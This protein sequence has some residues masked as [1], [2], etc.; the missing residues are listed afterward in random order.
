MA[1]AD[2]VIDVLKAELKAR[3][4][5]YAE[6]ARRIGMSEASVK[7]MFAERS[8]TL[9][10]L[11][12][13]CGAA[14]LEFSELTRGFSREQHL[15]NR[16]TE[17]QEREIV[18]EPK[19]FLAAMCALNLMSFDDILAAYQLTTA[20]LVGLLAR[21]DRIGIIEL[22]PNNRFRLKIARTFAWIPNGPIQTAFKGAA[23]DFFDS[24]FAAG[25][26]AMMLLNGRLSQ[27]SGAALIERLRQ[28]AREFSE[29]HIE[30]AQRPAEERPPMSLLLACRP[31]Q[32]QFMRELS[33][34]PAA[35]QSRLIRR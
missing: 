29:R 17:A 30:D 5:T 35:P 2:A 16:L 34:R 15:M 26:E 11:D 27:A 23:G 31:W 8:F 21:L 19:L 28:V 13:I 1:R 6:V 25:N 7:R 3:G 32:P 22:L 20:E 24:D 10:R 9:A 14:G 18:G 12:Q 4:L 33:R